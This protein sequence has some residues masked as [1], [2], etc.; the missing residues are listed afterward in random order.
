MKAVIFDM[1]GVIVDSEPRHEQA[2]LQVLNEIGYGGNHG[3]RVAD[4]I[5]RSDHELW[6][7]F[8]SRHKPVQTL[9]ELLGMKR[10]VVL[11]IIR[12]EQPVFD[13]LRE[14]V[15]KIATIYK[16]AVASGSERAVVQEVLALPGLQQFF[17]VA[18]SRADV[19]HGKPAPDIFLKA[20]ELLNVLPKEC[21]V[22]EDSKPGIAAGLAAGMRVIAITNTY[23]EDELRDATYVVRTYKEIETLLGNE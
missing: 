18:V 10:R 17:P 12:R 4:F 7:D 20:A 9:E 3:V 22:I 21:W 19:S 16:L 8:L 2:F 14:L 13:G 1:D 6:L 15:E 23:S 5:G 11:E